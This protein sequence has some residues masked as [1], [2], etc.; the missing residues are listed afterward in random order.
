MTICLVGLCD[1][2]QVIDVINETAVDL[3]E[4]WVHVTRDRNVDEEGGPAFAPLLKLTPVCGLKDVP[5]PLQ[6]R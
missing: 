4:G 2:L 1:L 5:P 6:W 3:V